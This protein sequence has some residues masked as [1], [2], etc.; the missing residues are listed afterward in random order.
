[1]PN[2][3]TKRGDSL[4]NGDSRTL[5]A[6]FQDVGGVPLDK[7]GGR[8]LWY[9]GHIPDDPDIES[10]LS[11]EPLIEFAIVGAKLRDSGRGQVTLLYEAARKVWGRDLDPGPQRIG[12]CVSWAYAGAVDLLACVEVLAGQAERHSWELRAG[13]E[14]IYALARVEYGNQDGS[15][16]DGAST[17]RAADAV[18]RGG[19][20]SRERIGA[21]DPARAR[22]WGAKGLPN[23]LEPEAKTHR[24]LTTARVKS[25]AEARDA[26]TNGYPVVIG[27]NQGFR[28]RR[29]NDGFAARYGSWSHAMKFVGARDDTR[30]GLLCMNSWGSSSPKGPKGQ[31]AIPDA[32]FWVD[33]SVCTSMFGSG[34]GYALS[35]FEGYPGRRESLQTLLKP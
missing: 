16:K 30:P 6:F 3:L 10:L 2:D 13:T 5:A 9:F 34:A 18:R 17:V 31:Y 14:A 32:S 35:L 28:T 29:D 12:D 7:G 26:I 25:F 19:T 22:T 33:A 8:I 21:Y 11:G 20:L 24:V 1:M 15:Y 23:T 4:D 27:S